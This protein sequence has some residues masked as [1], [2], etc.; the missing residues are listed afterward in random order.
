VLKE[1]KI[2]IGIIILILC[3]TP[4]IFWLVTPLFITKNVNEA[5]PKKNTST[6]SNNSPSKTT[7]KKVEIIKQGHFTK[8]DN[9]HKGSGS[10]TIY[11]QNNNTYFLRL[12]N[13]KVTNGPAL[14][15][16]LSTHL[17]PKTKKDLHSQPYTSLGKLK[18]NTGNQNY[19]IPINVN[20]NSIKSVIIHCKPFNVVFSTASLNNH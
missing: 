20:I 2:R 11:K 9:I 16:L 8:I 14:Q 17:S 12:E 15:V 5:L 10:A 3:L 19:T 1:V 7:I 18:G 4:A 13:F 6:H